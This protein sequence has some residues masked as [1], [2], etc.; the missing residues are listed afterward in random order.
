[1][2]ARKRQC[3]EMIREVN[4]LLLAAFDQEPIENE[5]ERARARERETERESER[6]R[7]QVPRS[8][9]DVAYV[10]QSRPDSGLGCQVK[11]LKAV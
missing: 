2:L 1:M 9:A 4:E 8:R 5:R 6:G 3:E 7:D 11:V 10:R